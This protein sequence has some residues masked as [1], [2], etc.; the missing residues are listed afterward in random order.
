[1]ATPNAVSF[2]SENDSSFFS[3]L[4]PNRGRTKFLRGAILLF[5]FFGT[6]GCLMVIVRVFSEFHARHSW[7]VAPG[8]LM[9]AT[10]KSYQ[11]PST[12]DHV[13]HYYVEYEVRFA[14]P[15]EQCLT[16]TT[17]VSDREP[18]ACVGTVRTRSTNSQALANTW[19]ERY[20]PNSRVDVLHDPNGPGVKIAGQS[21]SLVYPIREMVIMS[22]WVGF[23]LIFLIITQRR[24]E[25]LNTL[26][27]DY[28][29]PAPSRQPAGDDDLID[30]KLSK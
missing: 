3:T 30:L 8:H 26:P 14:V 4:M 6:I 22:A 18:P 10:V 16:G 1:M 19:L 20:Y 11:G 13:D 17:F 29:S 25:Y 9:A 23:F 24:L 7:P 12:S 21:A 5:L 28:D 2:A 15:V 27:E